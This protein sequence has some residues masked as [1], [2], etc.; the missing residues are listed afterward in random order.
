MH[1]ALSPYAAADDFCIGGQDHVHL[2][3]RVHQFSEKNYQIV[4]QYWNLKYTPKF[5]IFKFSIIAIGILML[6]FE[7]R[8]CSNPVH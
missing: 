8:G 1:A 2:T 6:S 3:P 5:E 4:H 7:M